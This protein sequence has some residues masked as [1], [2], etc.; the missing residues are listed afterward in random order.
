MFN[1][2]ILYITIQRWVSEEKHEPITK[3]DISVVV[4]QPRQCCHRFQASTKFFFLCSS[5]G[6]VPRPRAELPSL[7]P[8][9]PRSS[10][11][12][13]L[14]RP[15][16]HMNGKAQLDSFCTSSLHSSRDSSSLNIMALRQDLELSIA[17][18]PWGQLL[19]RE[20]QFPALLFSSFVSIRALICGPLSRFHISLL[21][22]S[23]S[24]LGSSL[25][26]SAMD[27]GNVFTVILQVSDLDGLGDG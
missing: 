14:G 15:W 16:A 10:S 27:S 9:T 4:P 3:S 1:V 19:M 6:S 26:F 22:V 17:R 21:M 2:T 24:S 5:G 18:M 13:I 23:M 7:A 11:G 8:A 12:T 25:H 20:T